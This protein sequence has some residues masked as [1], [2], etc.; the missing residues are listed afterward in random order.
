MV[1]QRVLIMAGG[2]GGHVFPGLALARY[3]QK[4]GID[5][6]WLG[7]QIGIEAQLVPKENVSLHCIAVNGLRGKGFG[8]VLKSP[9]KLAWAF[10]QSCRILH[11]I[12][13]DIVIGLGGFASGPGGVASWVMRYPLV[14]HEQNAKVGFTNKVLARFSNK[15]LEGL[16]EAFQSRAKVIVIGNPVRTEIENLSPPNE[17]FARSASPFRL[18]ILG[19]SLGAKAINEMV[20]KA[21]A[22]IPKNERP[23]ILHQTGK[24]HFDAT[25]QL[26]LSN[27][28]HANLVPFIED[29]AAAYEWADMA[30]CRAGALTVSELCAAGLGA[31]FVPYPHAVD[32]HQTANANYMVKHYAALCIQQANLNP[33]GLATVLKEY[34]Q[35]PEKRLAMAEAAYR[36]RFNEV[37]EKI[38]DILCAEVH[39]K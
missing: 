8:T 15:I 17:R 24:S 36:L 11:H 30:L 21:L 10:I 3:L 32:D 39:N 25:K 16:P 13:P 31:I 19:G 20:P 28:L 38:F 33:A 18:L 1:L 35:S 27:D 2:T 34:A 5:I 22:L 4:K 26:Y 12:Q 7:T 14:I 6:H 37:S 9:F 23:E 29:M